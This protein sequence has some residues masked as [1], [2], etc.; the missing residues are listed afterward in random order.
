MIAYS[1]QGNGSP[2]LFIHGFC[3]TKELWT[4]FERILANTNRIISVDLPGFGESERLIE[5]NMSIED[6]ADSVLELLKALNLEEIVIVG[7][8]LGG[9]VALAMIEKQL[10]ICK[11]LCMFHSTA[12]ADTEEKKQNRDKTLDFIKRQGVKSFILAFVP[13]LFFPNNRDRLV[14]EIESLQAIAMKTSEYT[15]NEITLAMRNRK[16]RTPVLESLSA[17]VLY[18]IGKND[19]AIPLA[20]SEKQMNIATDSRSLILDNTGHMGMYERR[21]T[22]LNAIQR[23]VKKAYEKVTL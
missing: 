18:I 8:S 10:S 4:D 20:I 14:S 5:D 22:T 23:F 21:E 16:D 15:V 2:I 17:P 13:S 1:D 7:H 12:F 19:L 6:L 9:Y 3:E 11:G